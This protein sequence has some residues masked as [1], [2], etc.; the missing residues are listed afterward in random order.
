MPRKKKYAKKEIVV[1]VPDKVETVTEVS[2]TATDAPAEVIYSEDESVT[3]N[4]TR[5]VEYLEE[6]D[7]TVKS[8]VAGLVTSVE[9]LLTIV[10]KHI[11]HIELPGP[12]TTPRRVF[13]YEVQEDGEKIAVIA[14]N[15]LGNAGRM[16]EICALN[17]IETWTEL[18]K[19][20]TLKMP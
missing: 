4:L 10:E 19:G 11:E 20:Q 1:E 17:G 15:Q 6:K 2:S 12:R 16:V 7:S 18:K 9:E 14:K 13:T 3:T 5:R 8:I